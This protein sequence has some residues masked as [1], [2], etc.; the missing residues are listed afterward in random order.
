[1]SSHGL[2]KMAKRM[3]DRLDK[4][5]TREDVQEHVGQ[6]FVWR[7]KEFRRAMLVHAD[8]HVVKELLNFWEKKLA[9][10]DAKMMKS[11][12]K[13]RLLATKAKILA[14]RIEKYS[15][16][17]DRIYA[18]YNYNTVAVIKRDVGTLFN[19]LTSKDSSLVTGRIDKGAKASDAQGT[20]VGHGD[21]GHAVSTT[22]VLAAE[23]A[24]MTKTMQRKYSADPAYKKIQSKVAA[25]KEKMGMDLT[26][27]HY[28]ELT[29]R[30]KLSK[31]YTA[32]LS[33]QQSSEN[34]S[35]AEKERRAINS[36]KK[37]L[38]EEY[39]YLL[40]MKGSDS[41]FEAIESVVVME[42]LTTGKKV[43]RT[44]GAA[45]KKKS[46]SKATS[47][48]SKKKTVT[49]KAVVLSGAGAVAPKRRAQKQRQ[50]I[51]SAP[52]K[53]LGILNQKLPE[54]VRKNMNSPALVNQTGRFADSVKVV[55]INQTPKGFPSVGYTYQKNPYEVFEDG[56]G[57]APWANGN[58]DPRQLI[59]KSIREIAVQFAIGRFYTRRL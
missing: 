25:Y 28:Q 14:L 44:K 11:V 40:N 50:S 39:E 16:T 35:D 13:R 47:T 6:I 32:I 12:H 18:V 59:D 52:L 51:S 48:Q 5:S 19:K 57:S 37:G 10:S 7:R 8:R 20:H 49:R 31:K 4:A 42:N 9:A 2:T 17:T 36:L 26:V 46:K 27:D 54:T 41:L 15:P 56:N 24:M 43:R 1:M 58:R 33:S 29:A 30:G 34:M 22:K 55:D 21:F 45:P 3:L 38:K 53:L 23:S